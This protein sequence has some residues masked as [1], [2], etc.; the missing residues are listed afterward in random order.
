MCKGSI[1]CSTSSKHRPKSLVAQHSAVINK[2]AHKRS[3]QLK[4]YAPTPTTL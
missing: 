2:V 3:V 1:S 4:F